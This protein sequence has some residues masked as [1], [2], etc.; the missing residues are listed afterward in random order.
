MVAGFLEIVSLKV[1]EIFVEYVLIGLLKAIKL[2]KIWS[3]S[4]AAGKGTYLKWNTTL[5]N[6]IMSP[7][8]HEGRQV[9]KKKSEE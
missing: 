3:N 5:S 1:K 7:K 9:F 4:H 6:L 8:E 2:S